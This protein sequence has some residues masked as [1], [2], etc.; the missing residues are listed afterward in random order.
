[1]CDSCTLFSIQVYL[2]ILSSLQATLTLMWSCVGWDWFDANSTGLHESDLVCVLGHVCL[3][4][5]M[6][7]EWLNVWMVKWLTLRVTLSIPPIQSVCCTALYQSINQVVYF[8]SFTTTGCVVLPFPTF[9]CGAP[10]CLNN[11]QPQSHLMSMSHNNINLCST[12]AFWHSN[13]GTAKQKRML[14]QVKR[15]IIVNLRPRTWEEW[16]HK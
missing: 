4:K 7:R 5:V 9:A 1:M 15:I 12:Q 11:A 10:V 16:T 13:K 14:I 6:K 2:V 8:F 3:L